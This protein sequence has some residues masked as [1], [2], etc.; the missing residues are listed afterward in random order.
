MLCARRANKNC[1]IHFTARFRDFSCL[2]YRSEQNIFYVRVSFGSYDLRKQFRYSLN[3]K[4]NY[5]RQSVFSPLLNQTSILYCISQI[6]G[7]TAREK[8]F[9]CAFMCAEFGSITSYF[10][11]NSSHLEA[12][13]SPFMQFSAIFFFVP[14]HTRKHFHTFNKDHVQ[15]SYQIIFSIFFP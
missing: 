1:Q 12:E 5:C 8:I 15:C 9:S 13:L 11:T 10:Q 7:N 3:A 14:K 6:V 4:P 2:I